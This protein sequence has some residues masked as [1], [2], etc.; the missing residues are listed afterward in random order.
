MR[1]QAH[2]ATSLNA[3]VAP[4]DSRTATRRRARSAGRRDINIVRTR[5]VVADDDEVILQLVSVLI[6]QHQDLRLVGRARDGDNALRLIERSAADVAVLDIRMP[7]LSGIEITRR[8]SARGAKTAAILY[9]G[10]ADRGLMLDSLDAG[11]RGYVLK[12][13]PLDDL[14]RAVR[15]VAGGRT[16]VDPA[17]AGTLAGRDALPRLTALTKREREILRLLADGMRNDAVAFE[18]S[19]SALTVRTHV[20][21]AMRKLE[22]DTRTHAVAQ[23]LRQSLIV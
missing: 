9:T 8:L 4:L 7:G 3:G 14:L 12:E 2:G 1:P 17:L 18:L 10:D 6:E 16:Y 20:N 11:A 23:A 21:N 22:C 15:M 19:I 5:C 13:A